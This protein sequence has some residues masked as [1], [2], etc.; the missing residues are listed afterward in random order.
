MMAKVNVGVQVI[1]VIL[2]NF[3]FFIVESYVGDFGL[4]SVM[5]LGRQIYFVGI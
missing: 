2:V 3:E 5:V 4:F 1:K